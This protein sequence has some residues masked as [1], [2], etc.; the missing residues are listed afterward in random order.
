MSRIGALPQVSHSGD[1]VW[2]RL[3]GGARMG[4]QGEQRRGA[5]GGQCERGAG[6]E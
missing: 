4:E 2:E 6:P 5:R 3:L 1:C